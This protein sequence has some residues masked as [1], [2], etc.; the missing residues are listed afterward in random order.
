MYTRFK[1]LMVFSVIGVTCTIHSEVCNFGGGPGGGF[2][3][4]GGCQSDG[5]C[6]IDCGLTGIGITKWSCYQNGSGCCQ[7]EYQDNTYECG[8]DHHAC[9]RR[10]KA[11]KTTQQAA[12]CGSSSKCVP[13]DPP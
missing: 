5:N 12:S 4:I 11:I 8:L 1:L 2:T 9:V 3:S 13:D 10:V 6:G 7:C